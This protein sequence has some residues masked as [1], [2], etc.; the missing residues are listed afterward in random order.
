M[1]FLGN[2]ADRR[3]DQAA[4]SE[5]SSAERIEQACHAAAAG[6]LAVRDI[7]EWLQGDSISEP[8][9]RLLWL[10]SRQGR[11]KGREALDQAQMAERLVV[12]PAQ[13][14]G[15]VER[16][17]SAGLLERVEATGDRR[18]QVWQ[19]TVSGEQLLQR[20]VDRVASL[21]SQRGAAA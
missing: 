11:G 8:E 16:L 9:F 14:S 12:S 13:V 10:L 21:G 20:I 5:C 18:R 19:V 15:A 2:Q 6:K 3:A 17:R 7:G 4:A 1:L